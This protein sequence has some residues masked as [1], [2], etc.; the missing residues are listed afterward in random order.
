MVA[1]LAHPGLRHELRDTPPLKTGTFAVTCTADDANPAFSGTDLLTT[2]ETTDTASQTF[3][4]RTP[5]APVAP[6]VSQG[7]RLGSLSVSWSALGSGVTDD[8]L[9]CYA[10]SADATDWVEDSK[11]SGLPVAAVEFAVTLSRANSGVVSLT[12]ADGLTREPVQASP[13]HPGT[14]QQ[15]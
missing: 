7:S 13:P 8:D 6:P 3:V 2:A 4:V 10:G 12:E 15:H 11:A 5:R 9:R 1:N 14:C